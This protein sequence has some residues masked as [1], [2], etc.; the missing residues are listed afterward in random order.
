MVDCRVDSVT[1]QVYVSDIMYWG[2]EWLVDLPLKERLKYLDR[3]AS[4][5]HVTVMHDS[6]LDGKVVPPEGISAEVSEVTAMEGSS[7]ACIRDLEGIYPYK[8]GKGFVQNKGQTK[9]S[10]NR[11]VN[12]LVV[13]RDKVKE[14]SF[15]YVVAVGPISRKDA[16]A[17]T[18]VIRDIPDGIN[19]PNKASDALVCRHNNYLYDV[20]GETMPTE[21]VAEV[22]EVVKIIVDSA[23]EQDCNGAKHYVV[24]RPIVKSKVD[25]VRMPD[26]VGVISR[27]AIPE[28]KTDV[29]KADVSASP[30]P[31]MASPSPAKGIKPPPVKK[32]GTAPLMKADPREAEEA[33][34][35]P[36]SEPPK[37]VKPVDEAKKPEQAEEA[38][39]GQPAEDVEPVEAPVEGEAEEARVP[40]D[41]DEAVLPPAGPG[42]ETREA[43]PKPEAVPPGEDSKEPAEEQPV[44]PAPVAGKH[45]ASTPEEERHAWLED[46]GYYEP[47]KQDVD[48]FLSMHGLQK[49]IV[50]MRI[51]D[52]EVQTTRWVKPEGYANEQ[53]QQRLRASRHAWERAGERT[54]FAAINKGLQD[55]SE[56]NLP[57]QDWFHKVEQNGYVVGIDSVIKTVLAPH[58]VPK[59]VKV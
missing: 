58:M 59:G 19:I 7:G 37:K 25:G 22:G 10:K 52:K 54:G 6:D 17:I 4:T 20:L 33:E 47:S 1:G 44:G 40:K 32:V 30:G 46:H 51:G 9:Y 27:F 53:K 21:I 39:A 50:P 57:N 15:T 11:E 5:E 23:T 29:T 36:E 49:K 12:V 31:V 55:L 41:T 45:V 8:E 24:S 16:D 42:E 2:K 14:G 48:L 13:G 34:A 56:R 35:A 28:E 18:T 3:I 38:E 26:R 43:N